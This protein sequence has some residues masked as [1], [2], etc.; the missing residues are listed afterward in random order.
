MHTRHEL[1]WTVGHQADEAGEP[2]DFVSA[3]VPGAVQLDWAAAQGWGD[4]HVA[5]RWN[6]YGW[7]EDCF[8][9]YR[10]VL[11]L[12]PRDA[13]ERV[14]FVCGGVDYRFRVC[15]CGETLHEQEGM[16]AP[17]ELDLTDCAHDGDTLD[18]LVFPAP[19]SHATPVDRSQANQSCKPAVSYGWDFHPRLIPLGIWRP[20]FLEI[21]PANHLRR[22]EVLYELSEDLAHAEIR[23]DAETSLSGP[24]QVR[25][26]LQAPDGT[27]ALM[28][29][30]AAGQILHARLEAPE[31]WWPHD[32]GAPG[33]YTA[34]VELR[35]AGRGAVRDTRELKV[36]FRRVRLIMHEGAWLEPENGSFPKS[37]SHPPITLEVNGRRVFGKGSNWVC[38]DIFPGRVT[39]AR[40][41]ELLTLAR[42]AG[43]NLLRNW[44]GAIVPPAEFHE[45]CDE[46]GIMVWQEFPLA[47]NRYE[48]TPAYLRVL[49]RESRAIVRSLRPHPSLVLWCGGN[50]LFN[51][52]S[53]MTDQ[54]LAL[55]LLNR[56]CYDL[57]P[58]RP[59]LPTSPL[60]GMGHGHYVFRDVRG[61]EV[62]QLFARAACT[63]Y[64]EFGCPGPSDEA[65]L[66]AILPEADLFP[67]K[68]G[69]AWQTH[70]AFKAW[71]D[72]SHLLLDVI[73]DY[74]GV[75]GTLAELVDH[76]QRLQGEGLTC[77]FEEA[78]RQ[79]P[80]AA[81]ALNWCFNEPWPAAANMSLINYPCVP[82]QA[83][84]AVARSLRPVLASA[85][86]AR[87]VWVAGETLAFDLFLLNDSPRSVPAGAVEAWIRLG[88]HEQLVL[89]WD[90]AGTRPQC[91]LAGPTA[92]IVLPFA[93]TDAVRIV[94]RVSG[95]PDWDSAYELRYRNPASAEAS[96]TRRLNM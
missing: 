77:L 11:A 33:L 92:R 64:T 13:G 7:M 17:F 94:L 32:Q 16:F 54:D 25:W 40:Y 31:L 14:V 50:E 6:D 15:L 46:L 38:P 95:H 88:V 23:L 81:M 76:G 42:D 69:T 85:R 56:T 66:R 18:V 70:H 49:E 57:D 71:A 90:H 67:P 41:R 93:E 83:Y 84:Q 5:D 80:R 58:Q 37:R 39:Q 91:N 28:A 30:G 62:Y 82:K 20:T 74:F 51:V 10:T 73:E 21:R 26:T 48:G 53:G 8:W 79:Q 43:M 59:F 29:E 63:A 45:L 96:G 35:D 78:R 34:R 24:E 87:F 55:R 19:K 47:C 44:G 68:P 27:V 65:T 36:G 3:C 12:P 4:P 61:D 1:T 86:F 60:D 72:N 89:R 75:S 22:A 2:A 52:W 9:R